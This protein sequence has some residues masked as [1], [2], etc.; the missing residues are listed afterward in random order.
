[1]ISHDP[2]TRLLL[3]EPLELPRRSLT[4]G[5]TS[6]MREGAGLECLRPLWVAKPNSVHRR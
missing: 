3:V 2:R 4:G 6:V 5:A 1:M